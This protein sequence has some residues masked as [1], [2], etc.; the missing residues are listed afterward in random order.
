[1]TMWRAYDVYMHII[2]E[3][4]RLA[5]TTPRAAIQTCACH[6]VR[7]AARAVT[8]TYD[9]MLRPTGLRATQLSILVAVAIDGAMS[10]TGLAKLL[11]TDRSTLT[12]NLRPLEDQGLIMIGP[13]GRYRSRTLEITKHGRARLGEALPLWEK[14]QNAL[15]A[16]LGDS[17]WAEMYGCL[18]NLISAAA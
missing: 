11:C 13:E 16:R 5:A 17:N 4:T 3:G 14:A 18:D 6:R 9:D 8:R 15:R 10:I 2:M 1:M 7:M 12:R